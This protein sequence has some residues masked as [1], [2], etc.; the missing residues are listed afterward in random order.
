MCLKKESKL[1]SACAALRQHA[2]GDRYQNA[3][4]LRLLNVLQHDALATLFVDHALVVRQIEGGG[5]DAVRAVAR[6]VDLVHHADRR[7]RAQLRIA[8]LRIDRQ[9]V[10]DLLQVRREV[11]QACRSPCRRG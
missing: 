10:L 4:E 6:R 11:L 5:A 7:R 9:V 1:R 8:V 3:L 2:S